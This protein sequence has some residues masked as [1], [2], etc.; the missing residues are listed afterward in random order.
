MSRIHNKIDLNLFRV[1]L[2]I[3]EEGSTTA[4]A[5]RLNLSQSA[6]SHA[7]KRLREMMNDPLFVKNG[8]NLVLSPHGKNILPVVRQSL[9]QLTHCSVK[10][11]DF[12]PKTSAMALSLGFRDILEFL[13]LPE[14]LA[15]LR[16][17]KSPLTIT[18]QRIVLADIEEQLL[19][20]ELDMVVDLEVPTSTKIESEQITEENLCVLV[21]EKHP[22][23]QLNAIS[24][25]EYS[26]SQHALVSLNRR[27][28]AYVDSRI[29]TAG[30]KRQVVL[31][32]EHYLPA[33]R[34]VVETVLL[35][36]MPRSYAIYLSDFLRVRILPLPFDCA[37]VP[38]RIYWRK[39]ISD[40][41]YLVWLAARLKAITQRVLPTANAT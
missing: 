39:E 34:T 9:S 19:S 32:C 23:F 21:G 20:G 2:A 26:A 1:M 29:K 5:T 15:P 38:I 13:I 4:A 31:H 14:L 30:I 28:R 22:C 40:E 25:E 8:R 27:E 17:M 18:S 11:R 10:T 12:D 6:V 37:P 41:P 24:S 7:L 33:A 3:A 35:L 16:S 36:T